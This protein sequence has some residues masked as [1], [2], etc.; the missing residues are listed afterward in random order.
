MHQTGTTPD[1]V[2][3]IPSTNQVAVASDDSN[4]L[5]FINATGGF[6]ETASVQLQP[7]PSVSGP[8]V[9]LYV[10][11]KDLIYQPVD[12]QIDVINP[13]TGQI[14][15]TF[16]LLTTGNVKPMVYDPVTNHLLVGTTNNQLLVVDA[17]KGTILKTIAVPGGVDQGTIDVSARLAFF[18]D[19]AGFADVVNWTRTNSSVSCPLRRVHIR[20]MSIRQLITSMFTKPIAT[21]STCMGSRASCTASSASWTRRRAITS[22]PRAST[23]ST[24][25]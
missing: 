5:D 11:Q 14:V 8:D 13:H 6:A 9:P 25:S 19:K 1:G 16:S 18:G 7:N 3:Y 4:V 2:I 17:D 23:S 15:N 12:Q 10:A 20:W 22:S 24:R 21:R